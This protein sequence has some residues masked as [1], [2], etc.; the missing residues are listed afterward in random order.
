MEATSWGLSRLSKKHHTVVAG[1]QG[2]VVKLACKEENADT[3]GSQGR[4][5]L[6]A[7]MAFGYCGKSSLT[8]CAS[9]M[10]RLA[11]LSAC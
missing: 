3:K 6:R 9:A 1:E 7:H 2:G 4:V 10:M 8:P 5:V 11:L